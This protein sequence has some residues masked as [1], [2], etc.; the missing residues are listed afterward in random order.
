[1]SRNSKALL[2]FF[3]LDYR[4][5]IIVF[6]CIFLASLIPIVIFSISIDGTMMISSDMAIAVFCAVSGFLLIKETF[7]FSI[8]M[9]A[10]R[11]EYV[12]N[13]LLFSVLLAAFMSALN[14]AVVQVLVWII[15]LSGWDNFSL[16]ILAEFFT[17]NVSWY[18]QYSVEFMICFLLFLLG[19][20]LSSVFHRFGMIGGGL[21][22]AIIFVAIL[23][24]DVHNA[25]IDLLIQ[26][27]RLDGVLSVSFN[28]FGILGMATTL[29][30][31]IWLMLRNAPITPGV[32][33]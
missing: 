4:F 11:H 5:S 33:R 31:L 30:A 23:V 6:W 3:T 18:T 16:I 19:F 9:G 26:T 13:A 8:R 25:L 24:P 12:F 32:T 7:P 21:T 20:F 15:E 28:N 1:M 10:T 22:L 27:E 17:S 29:S 14:L 2:V